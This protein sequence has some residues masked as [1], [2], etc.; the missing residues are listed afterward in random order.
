MP[1]QM[2]FTLNGV[3]NLLEKDE[4]HVLVKLTYDRFTLTARGDVMF[5]LPDDKKVDVKVSYVDARGHPAK[6]DG[7]VMWSSS[8]ENVATVT[9]N[10]DQATI[11]PASATG[12][13]LGQVQ[14]T[15]KADADLGAGTRELITTLDV[16]V[17]AGDAVMGTIQ[18][19]GAPVPNP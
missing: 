13:V 7:P 14:I 4:G 18:P 8:D 9:P 5:T 6:V 11:V 1:K 3:L 10:G 19:V 15:A 16:E 2:E 17:V 12:A